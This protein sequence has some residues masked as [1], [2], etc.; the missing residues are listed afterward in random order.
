MMEVVAGLICDHDKF[1]ICQRGKNKARA[2]LW[3]FAGGKVEAGET[4]P[5][6]LYRELKEE[7]T[8]QTEIADSCA[9]VS[10][11]YPDLTIHLTLYRC[12]IVSG[13]VQLLEHQACRWITLAQT[14]QFEFC[15]ADT[16]LIQQLKLTNKK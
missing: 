1:L 10:Y 12:K 9:D 16:L 3:E 8:I 11:Q 2:G 7:L 6:A 5:Q 4:G 14:D 13:S 15:P